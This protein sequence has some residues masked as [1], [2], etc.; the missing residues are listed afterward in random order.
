MFILATATKTFQGVVFTFVI[1]AQIT[2]ERKQWMEAE[3]MDVPRCVYTD[4]AS[5]RH[6][7]IFEVLG[8]LL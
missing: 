1:N 3:M 4:T 5:H 7:S 8:H 2:A 6:H